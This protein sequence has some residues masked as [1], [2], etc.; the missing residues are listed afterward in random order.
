M[1]DLLI[2]LYDFPKETTAILEPVDIR[3]ALVLEKHIVTAW[4][5]TQFNEGW[6]SETEISFS[7]LPAA[8]FVAT[9]NKD[10]VGFCCYDS[11]ARGVLGPMGVRADR[12]KGGIG[13]QL[14]LAALRDMKSQGY[15]Y[16]V[17][18]WADAVDFY[19]KVAGATVIEGSEPGIYRGLL[20][21][22]IDWSHN[23]H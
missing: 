2:K 17:V 19:Q 20:S 21:G 13:R 23:K 15:A 14:L 11:T 5:S 6:A 3:R 10:M 12:R 8:C 4:V 18:G 9:E 22:A 7:R 1:P 16:A